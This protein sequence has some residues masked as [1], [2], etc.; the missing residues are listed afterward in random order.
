MSARRL[1]VLGNSVSLVP[2]KENPAVKPYPSLLAERLK[3]HDVVNASVDGGTAGAILEV[4]LTEVSRLQPSAV[5]L[6]AG[7]VDCTPRPLKPRER[8]LLAEVRPGALRNWSVALIHQ[9]RAE[10]IG[11]RGLIQSTPLAAFESDY[12]RLTE[13]CRTG[14][15]RVAA[16]A[17]FPPTSAV[18][19]RNPS[20]PGEIASYNDAIRRSS[21]DVRVFETSELFGSTPIDALC[22]SPESV[23]LNQEGHSLIAGVLHAWIELGDPGHVSRS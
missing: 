10:I 20:L 1:L 2:K 21:R 16:L 7:I 19:R 14:A 22:V 3:D 5:V 17:I 12:R 6:Q 4:A 18:L 23:H 13:A 9:Y 15:T 11:L 8:A